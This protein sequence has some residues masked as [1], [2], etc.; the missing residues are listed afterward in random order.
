MKCAYIGDIV[1]QK[2]LLKILFKEQIN[3]LKEKMD[4]DRYRNASESSYIKYIPLIRKYLIWYNA[5]QKH[6]IQSNSIKFVENL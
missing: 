2:K 4:I 5:I 1:L 6:S 3:G